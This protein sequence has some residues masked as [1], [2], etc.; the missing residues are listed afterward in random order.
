MIERKEWEST[1]KLAQSYDCQK[2]PVK[3][4]KDTFT[5][6]VRDCKITHIKQKFLKFIS[7]PQPGVR[8]AA[9]PCPRLL[10]HLGAAELWAVALHEPSVALLPR[11][12][13]QQLQPAGGAQARET[14]AVRQSESD[15]LSADCVGLFG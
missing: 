9:P 12:P 4:F 2:M 1:K 13:G 5:Y 8:S 3:D 14:E 11:H 10:V 7:D 6:R 15:L